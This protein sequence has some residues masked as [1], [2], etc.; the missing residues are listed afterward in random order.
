MK[1]VVTKAMMTN[2][3]GS[4]VEQELF[5]GS[6]SQTLEAD[7]LHHIQFGWLTLEDGQWSHI[8]FVPDTEQ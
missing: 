2:I 6:D 8:G 1:V 7:E 4:D 5:D 3:L